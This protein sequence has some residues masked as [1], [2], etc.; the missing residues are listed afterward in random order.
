[1][2][3]TKIYSLFIYLDNL[4]HCHFVKIE[5]FLRRITYVIPA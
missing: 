2:L 3:F 4:I 1:M 5:K